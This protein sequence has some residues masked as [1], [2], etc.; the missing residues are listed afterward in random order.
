MKPRAYV[1]PPFSHTLATKLI[2]RQQF[3]DQSLNI[4]DIGKLALAWVPN[5]A[6]GG[7]K[8]VTTTTEEEEVAAD[9]DDDDDSSATVGEHEIKGEEEQAVKVEMDADL[10]VADDVD[11]WL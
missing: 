1:I 4:P 11:Q 10:D 9:N 8:A 7:L 2:H 3:L 5:D 6:F